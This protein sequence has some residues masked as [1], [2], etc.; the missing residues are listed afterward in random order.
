MLLGGRG[1]RREPACAPGWHR[2]AAGGGWGV[3]PGA[4]ELRGLGGRA[5]TGGRPLLPRS[6]LREP[7]RGSRPWGSWGISGPAAPPPEPRGRSA[8]GA[9]APGASERRAPSG[10]P[11]PA[12]PV[13][14][15]GGR[16][17]TRGPRGCKQQR[18][19]RGPA[20]SFTPATPTGSSRLASLSHVR[21]AGACGACPGQESRAVTAPPTDGPGSLRPGPSH[22]HSHPRGGKGPPGSEAGGGGVNRAILDWAGRGGRLGRDR[23][24]G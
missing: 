19:Q 18:P 23:S 9:R 24:W 8:W 6:D 5:P 10:D 2:T 17:R 21:G 12:Q 20:A 4:G 22:L 3:P 7:G 11:L 16:A 13:G 14:R 15:S 1:P